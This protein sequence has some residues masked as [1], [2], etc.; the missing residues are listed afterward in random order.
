M[1]APVPPSLT[2]ALRLAGELTSCLEQ[3]RTALAS[4]RPDDLAQN[5]REKNKLIDELQRAT[6][7]IHW[8][9]VDPL[10]QRD[11]GAVMRRCKQ[12]NLANA[13]LLEARLV[14]VRWAMNHLGVGSPAIYGR[15]GKT[16]TR[17]ATRSVGSA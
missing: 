17:F 2:D 14:Q 1:G 3:E 13:A 15:D 8:E 7:A 5:T 16:D 6:Q 4:G 10:T 12:L 11:L 9:S